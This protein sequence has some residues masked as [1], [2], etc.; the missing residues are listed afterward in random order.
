MFV[1]ANDFTGE[2]QIADPGQG[3]QSWGAIVD[4]IEEKYLRMLLGNDQ[5]LE[6]IDQWDDS[7]ATNYNQWN[8]F[9]EGREYITAD[10]TTVFYKGVKSFLK[11]FVYVDLVKDGHIFVSANQVAESNTGGSEVLK[12]YEKEKF[13]NERFNLGV[14]AYN[15][16]FWYLANNDDYDYETGY[17]FPLQKKTLFK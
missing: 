17:F 15:R 6:L 9:V 12:G 10:N 7:T 3:L 11:Y 14:S 13:L 1:T 2:I 16:A 4:R 5:F 8:D